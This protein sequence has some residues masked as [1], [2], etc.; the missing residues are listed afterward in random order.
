MKQE[1][2]ITLRGTCKPTGKRRIRI[3]QVVL[4]ILISNAWDVLSEDYFQKVFILC[5]VFN[6]MVKVSTS[7]FLTTIE[8]GRKSNEFHKR[9]HTIS[10]EFRL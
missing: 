6:G 10:S 2:S 8:K 4:F 3:H 1:Y 9:I 5:S 7:L